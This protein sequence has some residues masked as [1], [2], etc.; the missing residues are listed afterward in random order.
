MNWQLD[1]IIVAIFITAVI[2][3]I[4]TWMAWRRRSI[5][6]GLQL[7]SLMLGVA[8]WSFFTALEFTASTLIVRTWL[9]RFQ[10]FGIATVP[11]SYLIFALEYTNHTKWRKKEYFLLLWTIPVITIILAFTNDFHHLIWTK[12][13]TYPFGDNFLVEYGHG[14]GLWIA[15]IYFYACMLFGFILVLINTITHKGVY[16]YQGVMVLIGSIFPW[17][18]NVIYMLDLSP[19]PGVDFSCIAFTI[20]SLVLIWAVLRFNL[21]DLVPIARTAVVDMMRDGVIVLD[22]Q[23]RIIDIN[24][25]ACRMINKKASEVIGTSA[26]TVFSHWPSFPVLST[27]I[28]EFNQEIIVPDKPDMV[29]DLRISS[30]KDRKKKNHGYLLIM[31]DITRRKH[32]EDELARSENQLR[33]I[34]DNMLDVIMEI[35]AQ[36]HLSYISPSVK[37]L[38]GYPPDELIGRSIYDF[39]IPADHIEIQN[40]ISTALNQVDSKTALINEFRCKHASKGYIWLEVV[41]HYLKNSE[42]NFEGAIAVCRDITDRKRLYE[43]EKKAQRVTEALRQVGLV[44]SSTL[45]L[46]QV[47]KLILEQANQVLSFDS[48]SVLLVDEDS[49]VILNTFGFP[50]NV[51]L[52]GS[53][54]SLNDNNPNRVVF[55]TGA[56]YIV[57][58]VQGKY[59]GFQ[60]EHLKSVHSWMG[61]PLKY[62]SKMIGMLTFDS[63]DLNHFTQDDANIAVAFSVPVA[64]AIVNSLLYAE[65]EHLATTDSLTGLLT[66]HQFFN[67]AEI[68][69]DRA[70][71]YNRPL[72]LIMVDIDHFKNVN[73]TYGHMI[74]DQVLRTLSVDCFLSVLRKMDLAGR[75]GGEEIVLLLPETTLSSAVSVAERIRNLVNNTVVNSP[76][77]PIQTT[78]SLGVATLENSITTVQQ[79]IATADKA[80]YN[81]KEKGRNRVE[82]LEN[83]DEIPCPDIIE[84]L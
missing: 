48:A 77:G 46:D 81:A 59:E 12:F 76:Y 9:S 69:V 17:I 24:F 33:R 31:Q 84:P 47:S 67:L 42:G 64:A 63:K 3:G 45:Q 21:L 8:I 44:L 27:V 16:R 65:M 57:D 18:G 62:K 6:G 61:I 82:F 52:A 72:S 83:V 20:S 41:I 2:A 58:D 74:G 35:D 71:R 25:T 75:Y 37:D 49:M 34:T 68:E 66:R 36:M 5:T 14:I 50:P 15:T 38:L 54:F 55:E 80:L 4:L 40:G 39:V 11:V 10:Y 78:I 51:E 56:P 23:K 28:D 73:D 19:V 53:R 32:A 26:K 22:S 79:L 29:I 7:A 70:L 43:A 60:A 30:L 13:V 1:L